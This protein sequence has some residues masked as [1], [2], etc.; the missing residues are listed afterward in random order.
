[1]SVVVPVNECVNLIF[2][3]SEDIPEDFYINIMNLLKVYY[4]RGNNLHEIHE[5]LNRNKNKINILL[6]EKIKASLC[7]FLPTPRIVKPNICDLF[8]NRI[9]VCTSI[10]IICS[11]PAVIVVIIILNLSKV[12]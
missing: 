4:D 3:N 8:Y 1:M 2:E 7:D 9:F 10:L 12:H 5:F 11:V 6:M